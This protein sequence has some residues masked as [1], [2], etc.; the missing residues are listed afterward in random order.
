MTESSNT[1][2]KISEDLYER[3]SKF[4]FF[5]NLLDLK[6]SVFTSAYLSLLASRDVMSLSTYRISGFKGGG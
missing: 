5:D 3:P 2:A 6:P 4:K 1:T